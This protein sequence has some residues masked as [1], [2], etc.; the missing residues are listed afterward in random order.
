[1]LSSCLPIGQLNKSDR[2]ERH[3]LKS[4]LFFP[5]LFPP[6]KKKLEE[7]ENEVSKPDLNH[8]FGSRA[9]DGKRFLESNTSSIPGTNF[10]LG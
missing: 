10:R 3:D 7:K 9:V 4:L 8:F 2:A 6:K 1:M 5:F